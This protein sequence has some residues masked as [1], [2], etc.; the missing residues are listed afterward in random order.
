MFPHQSLCMVLEA[1]SSDGNS[2]LEPHLEMLLNSLFPQVC[3]PIDYTKPGTLKNH[4]EL[5]RCYNVL[6]TSRMR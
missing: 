5:L 4:N 2:R 1:G 3:Q 6:G